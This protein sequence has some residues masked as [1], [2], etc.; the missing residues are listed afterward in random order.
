M[1]ENR[2]NMSVAERLG[3]FDDTYGNDLDP[4]DTIR[5]LVCATGGVLEYIFG[6]ESTERGLKVMFGPIASEE[7]SWREDMWADFFAEFEFTTMLHGLTAYG[8]FGYVPNAD[9]EDTEAEIEQTL[10]H[11]IARAEAFL[12]KCPLDFWLGPDRPPQLEN[13][14]RLARGR[15]NLDQGKPIDAYALALLGGVSQG[16][17]RNMISGKSAVFRAEKGMVP[18]H[19]AQDW[20]RDRDA[21][22]PSIWR[23]ERINWG[24]ATEDEPLLQDPVFVPV[25]RDGDVFHP[26]LM[27]AGHYTVG[28]KGE[29]SRYE[30]FDEALAALT[31]MPTPR[32]RQPGKGDAPSW[33]LVSGISW[34]RSTTGELN[35]IAQA[36]NVTKDRE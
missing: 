28:A 9:D 5:E 29:E 31:K 7:E 13:T 27:R 6:E 22:F 1:G 32:W 25:T 2:K 23:Q 11:E 21:F 15:L 24:S 17:M 35:A 26:G 3:Y 4:C 12:A 30:T 36:M 19:E 8:W 18:I 10:E 33:S 20:L 34:K 16:R 14:V